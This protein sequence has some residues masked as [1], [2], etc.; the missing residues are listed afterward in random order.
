MVASPAS[1]IPLI[2]G[3]LLF[4]FVAVP[5]YPPAFGQAD[6]FAETATQILRRARASRLVTDMAAHPTVASLL[7][8]VPL[9]VVASIDQLVE[10]PSAV[11]AHV[12]PGD[13]ALL[14]FTSGS[15]SQPKGVCVTHATLLANARAI[16]TGL[17]ATEQDRGVCW[18]PLYHD[19]GLIGF[20]LASLLTGTP[21]TFIPTPRFVRDPSIWLRSID[22]YRGTIT[23]APN[24]AYALTTKRVEPSGFD[25]SS[26]RMWGCG[27]EPIQSGT[28]ERF[29]QRFS[30]CGVRRGQIAPCYGL[31]EATL[32]VA[33]TPPS[34]LRA[35]DHIDPERYVRDS[36]AEP[37]SAGDSAMAVVA[38][39]R[40]L[41]LH[42]VEIRGPHGELLP[43]RHAGEIVV[44]GP[45]VTPGYYEQSEATQ[46]NFRG[47]ALHTGDKG[48]LA[49]GWLYVTGR[50]KDIV[51]LHGRNYDPQTLE[52]AVSSVPGV[53]GGNVVAFNRPGVDGDELVIVAE[54][55]HS[56][57]TPRTLA[58]A[59]ANRTGVR[60]ADI[61]LLSAGRL[62]KTTSGKLQ[63]GKARELYLARAFSAQ[64]ADREPRDG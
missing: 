7:E 46:A 37:C 1:Y 59:L 9:D 58:D 54:T 52:D 19:M 34:T 6:T 49:D 3:C 39:G 8:R 18:L 13:T 53:R 16:T 12:S 38:C 44:R 32:A 41:P 2:H 55:T 47:D 62:P 25:L 35:T 33:F 14:Q 11:P 36:V 63:R 10:D 22:Q 64:A 23:F 61:L 56:Q 28:L 51:I 48:Y 43:E 27:A 42:R 31:A 21:V 57:A 40:P 50:L 45:S 5:L 4:G 20:G 29:E 17:G 15:T 24:F 60:A 30:S 26:V